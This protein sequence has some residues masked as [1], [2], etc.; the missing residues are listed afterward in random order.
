MDIIFDA[1]EG[2]GGCMIGVAVVFVILALI[3]CC[4]GFFFV[5]SFG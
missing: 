3:F 1:F 5:G 2:C 4:V